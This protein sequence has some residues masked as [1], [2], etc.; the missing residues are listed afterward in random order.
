[1]PRKIVMLIGLGALVL[2]P[3]LSPSATMAQTQT[4]AVRMPGFVGSAPSS[5]AGC[6]RLMWRL[7]RDG[8]NVNGI[9]YY[10][11]LSGT[12]HVTGTVDQSGHFTLTATSV[13]GNGPVGTITG[14][15]QP[16]NPARTQ[17]AE[18]PLVATMT[19]QGCANMHIT[20]RAVYNLNTYGAG[21]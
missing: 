5:V 10:A 20:M 8:D 3:V 13:M 15:R 21:G 4:S 17:E 12:S 1:M 2:A 18:G 7:A 19:G 11:D 6:P 16:K 9:L 14:Q